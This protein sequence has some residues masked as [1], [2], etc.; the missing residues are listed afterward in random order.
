MIKKLFIQ[1][2]TKAVAV[3]E[4]LK[5]IEKLP[6]RGFADEYFDDDTEKHKP[7]SRTNNVRVEDLRP[8]KPKD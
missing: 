5:K 2:K 7:A 4:F 6:M 8:Q 3:N 1:I